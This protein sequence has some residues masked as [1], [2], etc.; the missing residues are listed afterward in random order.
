MSSIDSVTTGGGGVVTT[1]DSSGTMLLKTAGVT[2][3]TIDASQNVTIPYKQSGIGAVTRTVASKLNDTVSVKDFGAVGDGVTDDTAAIQAA[4]NSVGI[5]GGGGVYFPYGTYKVTSTLTVAYNNVSF[6]GAN[7]RGALLYSTT[8]N[9]KILSVTGTWFTLRDM[10]F[11][12]STTP[13]SGAVAI[14]LASQNTTLD[15]FTVFKSY[16]GLQLGNGTLGSCGAARVS[17]FQILSHVD[18]GIYGYGSLDCFFSNGVINAANATNAANGNIHLLNANEAFVMENVDMLLGVYAIVTDAS[19]Y[20]SSNRTAYSKFSNVFFD[21]S[22]QGTYL[23]N[24]VQTSFIGCWFSNGRTG[25]GYFGCSLNQSDEI[26]FVGCEFSN[27]GGGGLNIAASAKRTKVIG[28]TVESNSFTAGAGVAHG[29]VIAANTSD[30]IITNN[31]CHNGL[32]PGTQGYGILIN[33]NVTNFIVKDNNLLGNAS[34]AMAVGTLGA[35]GVITDNL[36]FAPGMTIPTVTASP[37][38][39]TAGPYNET[40]YITGG[41]ISAITVGGQG[42]FASSEKTIELAPNEPVIIT[43]SVAPTVRSMRH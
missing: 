33:S 20:T 26:S 22:S 3:I 15:N 30:F 12:Y 6:I 10:S 28:C 29:I 24:L 14:Y 11:D 2:A 4:I 21:S 7:Q 31:H 39:Y 18:A 35:G 8:N 1:A 27:C 13:I 40:V 25:P 23:N 19:S 38:T 32:F 9:T 41:T 34:G 43:Y 16:I 5:G 37:F 42:V 17:N 36:G